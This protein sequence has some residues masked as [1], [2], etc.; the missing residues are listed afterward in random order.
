MKQYSK[1]KSIAWLVALSAALV[2]QANKA[3]AEEFQVGAQVC[4]YMNLNQAKKLEYRSEGVLN[5]NTVEQW[6]VCPIA[7]QSRGDN[8]DIVARISNKSNASGEV[9][10]LY[11]LTNPFGVTIRQF[12]QK[13]DVGVG[14]TGFL[15]LANINFATGDTLTISCKLPPQFLAVS[16]TVET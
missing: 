12:S 10:V 11:K 3:F 9:Q 1:A 16:F 8:V 6:V 2:F 5:T 7:T 14:E 15:A 4:Q 13:L